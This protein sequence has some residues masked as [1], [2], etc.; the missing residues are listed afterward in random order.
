MNEK[1]KQLEKLIKKVDKMKQCSKCKTPKPRG[2]FYSN[3]ATK[4]RLASWCKVCTNACALNGYKENKEQY[5]IRSKK[6]YSK[7]KVHYKDYKKGL[8]CQECGESRTPCL[9]FHHRNPD[10]KEFDIGASIGSKSME[11]IMKEIAKCDVL[12]ANCHCILHYD[13]RE[14]E[15]INKEINKSFVNIIRLCDNPSYDKTHI[16]QVANDACSFLYLKQHEN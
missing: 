8:K 7:K 1:S 14:T 16:R 2:D 10:E 12:C 11:C 5:L 6:S 3:K 13:L 15:E 4:G 9:V